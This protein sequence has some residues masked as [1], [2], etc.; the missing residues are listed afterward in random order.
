MNDGIEEDTEFEG[1]RRVMVSLSTP[2]A[3]RRVAQQQQH[4][5]PAHGWSRGDVLVGL[6]ALVVT[7]LAASADFEHANYTFREV[8]IAVCSVGFGMVRNRKLRAMFAAV[9]LGLAIQ[10]VQRI[11]SEE[12]VRRLPE[13]PV[14]TAA[15][16]SPTLNTTT[17]TPTTATPTT[18][19]PTTAKP[20]SSK[21]TGAPTSSRAVANYSTT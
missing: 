20:T 10:T 18:A 8:V 19:T 16:V 15:T 2:R 6:L 4:E 7:L 12:H 13:T 5:D 21:P 14:P 3:A 9:A 1:E 11:I 17:P